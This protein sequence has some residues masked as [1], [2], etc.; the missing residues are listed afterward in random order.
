M[1]SGNSA[2]KNRYSPSRPS[3]PGHVLDRHAGNPIDLEVSE[4]PFA[5]VEDSHA[6]RQ[7]W[8]SFFVV[9]ALGLVA[10]QE[11]SASRGRTS[12]N[13]LVNEFAGQLQR[14][15]NRNPASK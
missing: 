7:I 8:W 15:A 6:R 2:P 1:E 3:Q 9:V 12:E 10:Y 14:D 4:N 5:Q 13:V 11:V